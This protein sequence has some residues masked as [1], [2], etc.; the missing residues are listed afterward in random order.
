VIRPAGI[1]CAA[2]VD[3][4]ILV[5]W[6]GSL[7][8]IGRLRLIAS[9]SAQRASDHASPG[10]ATVWSATR[11]AWSAMSKQSARHASAL[12]A[13]EYAAAVAAHLRVGAAP[14]AALRRAVP[15]VGDQ[16]LKGRL[17][18]MVEAIRLGTD[19]A[20]ALRDVG[21]ASDCDLLR[22]C[23]AAWH[24][25]EVSGASLATTVDSIVASGRAQEAQRLSVAAALAGPRATTRLLALLPVGGLLLGSVLGADPVSLLLRTPGGLTC[26]AAGLILQIVGLR[27]SA[28]LVRAAERAA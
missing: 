13:M 19:P 1:L 28:A 21:D 20:V 14:E 7:G 23:A 9:A 6:P 17:G 25:A 4:S 27:W 22:W 16:A 12:A 24:V 18:H 11:R 10:L 2:L 3:I 26:L 15:E 8:R 5:R